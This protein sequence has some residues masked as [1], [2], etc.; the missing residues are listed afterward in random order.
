MPITVSTWMMK[1]SKND[2]NSTIEPVVASD[3]AEG[4]PRTNQ[5]CDMLPGSGETNVVA[6]PVNSGRVTGMTSLILKSFLVAMEPTTCR[7]FSSLETASED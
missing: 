6:D 4:F 1:F 3:T 7:V 2:K 5:K